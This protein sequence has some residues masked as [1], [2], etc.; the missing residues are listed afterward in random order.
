M[1]QLTQQLT[2]QQQFTMW[3]GGEWC[4]DDGGKR[5][6]VWWIIGVLWRDW[7]WNLSIEDKQSLKEKK[8]LKQFFNDTHTV[9]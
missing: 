6:L 4:F 8:A 3:E 9:A 7:I 1:Q 2:N 5:L